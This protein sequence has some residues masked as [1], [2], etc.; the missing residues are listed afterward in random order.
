[1]FTGF[2]NRGVLLKGKI[3]LRACGYLAS[4]TAASYTL[5]TGFFTDSYPVRRDPIALASAYMI[6]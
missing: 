3:K 1:M 6:S 5:P 2:F 4:V